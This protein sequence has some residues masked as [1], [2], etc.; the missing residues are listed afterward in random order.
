MPLGSRVT[1]VDAWLG[2]GREQCLNVRKQV[3]LLTQP[4]YDKKKMS[5]PGSLCAIA[6]RMP[7]L[8]PYELKQRKITIFARDMKVGISNEIYV[9]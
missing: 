8:K 7:Y 9:C 4:E 6:L 2:S 5:L 3:C 1:V